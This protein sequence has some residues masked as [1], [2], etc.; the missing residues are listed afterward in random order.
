MCYV[1]IP[2]ATDMAKKI[3][4]GRRY[5]KPLYFF[6]VCWNDHLGGCFSLMYRHG[7]N[8]NILNLTFSRGEF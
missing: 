8:T 7:V 6:K 2:I 4:L 1:F 5:D 3:L